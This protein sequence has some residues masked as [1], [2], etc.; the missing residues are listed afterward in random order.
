VR[1]SGSWSTSADMVLRRVTG[2]WLIVVL[3]V[4]AGAEILPR[5]TG[6]EVL[7][8]VEEQLE[9]VHDYSVTLDVTVHLKGLTV[10][11]MTVTMYFKQPDKVHFAADRFALLPREG[12][13]MSIG[14]LR[15]RYTVES[16]EEDS[17]DGKQALC[18]MLKSQSDRTKLRE[19]R[20]LV[21]PQRWTIMRLESTLLDGRDMVV[22]FSYEAVDSV[23]L[24]S[25]MEVQF[26]SASPDTATHSF[27]FDEP[28]SQ[29]G[30]RPPLTGSVFI[31]YSHY[32][33]N[34]GLSDELF[35][36]PRSSGK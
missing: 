32:R 28:T 17:L 19:I 4:L 11:P 7:Q 1:F 31:T 14:Q 24:P 9:G 6:E 33:L 30:R 26:T 21:D 36:S 35:S 3:S 23:L 13:G 18:L 12:L 15:S 16:V 22:I 34:Q 20:A 2:L 10:Q 27:F 25:T 29:Q 5:L 8:R